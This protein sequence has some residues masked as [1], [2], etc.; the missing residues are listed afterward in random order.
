M[1]SENRAAHVAGPHTIPAACSAFVADDEPA[2][3]QTLGMSP[4]AHYV[5]PTGLSSRKP[6]PVPTILS[7]LVSAAMAHEFPHASDELSTS[8][9]CIVMTGGFVARMAVPHHQ[10]PGAQ[11]GSWDIGLQKTGYINCG[12]AMPGDA[13]R[14]WPGASL[15]MVLLDSAGKYSRMGDAERIRKWISANRRSQRRAAGHLGAE[16]SPSIKKRATG[17]LF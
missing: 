6:E 10:R 15:I 2:R 3:P 12:R 9:G 5:E 4:H 11:P 14:R 1:S 13:G 8:Q 17:A 16:L 7:L